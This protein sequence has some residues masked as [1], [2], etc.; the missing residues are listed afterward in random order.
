MSLE[1]YVKI[2]D[3]HRPKGIPPSYCPIGYEVDNHSYA[4]KNI[5]ITLGLSLVGFY[6]KSAKVIGSY[7]ENTLELK[8]YKSWLKASN[9]KHRKSEK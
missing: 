9:R 4:M 6:P 3:K 2:I 1:T 8:L 7:N 5:K